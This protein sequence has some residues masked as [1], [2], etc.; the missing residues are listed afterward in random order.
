MRRG[1]QSRGAAHA[2]RHGRSWLRGISTLGACLAIF[3]HAFF[4]QT[5]V[6]GLSHALAG[7]ERVAGDGDVDPAAPHL[8]VI[9]DRGDQKAVCL[10]CQALAGSGRAILAS[11]PQLD[12]ADGIVA[13]EAPAPIRYVRVAPSHAWRSRAPPTLL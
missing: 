11:A 2:G 8:N 12:S 5:H 6:E 7:V 10:I 3:L 4:V 9:A 13:A 1:N